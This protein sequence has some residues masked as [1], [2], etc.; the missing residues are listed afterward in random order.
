MNFFCSKKHFYI[1]ASWY[2]PKWLDKVLPSMDIEGHHLK[3]KK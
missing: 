3:D 2:M 1:F